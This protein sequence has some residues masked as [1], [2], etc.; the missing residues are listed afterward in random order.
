MK[1]RLRKKIIKTIFNAD[2]TFFSKVFRFRYVPS[3]LRHQY[4]ITTKHRKKGIII[5]IE[6]KKKGTDNEND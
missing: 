6:I 2:K 4:A 1:S 3:A 5:K